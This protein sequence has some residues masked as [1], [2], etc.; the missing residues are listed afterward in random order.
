MINMH[1]RLRVP[2]ES[3]FLMPL[4][5]QLPLTPPLDERQKERAYELISA[6]VRWKDWECA[7]EVLRAA[8]FSEKV[9]NLAS[10][11]NQIFIDCSDMRGKPRWGDKTPQ[12]S[13]YVDQLHQ[14]FPTAKFI[15]LFRD[16]RDTCLSMKNGGWCEGDMS[17]IARK[18]T[19]MTDF[20]RQG[21]A[22]GPEH[23]LEISYESMVTEPEKNLR[24]I[25]D[26]LGESYEAGMLDFYRTAAEETA[27]WENQLHVKTRKPVGAA[28]VGVWR[29]ALSRWDIWVIESYASATMSALGQKTELRPQTA[30][31]RRV[32]RS[33]LEAKLRLSL[34]WQKVKGRLAFL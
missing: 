17:R 1:S 27:P 18:W 8:I 13:Y 10:L 30:L 32:L 29:D 19:G 22:L 25:C 28:N 34:L 7:D 23:Y 6:H 20:A 12:Y 24:R 11:V 14:V 3:W 9:T 21:L 4:L 2:R 15:H 26:F 33:A 31:L 16:A 5:D